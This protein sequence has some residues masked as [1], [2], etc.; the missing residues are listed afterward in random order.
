MSPYLAFY[1][2]AKDTNPDP[3]PMRVQP[4]NVPAAKFDGLS[5]EFPWWKERPNTLKLSSLL[6][7]CTLSPPSN[8]NR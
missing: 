4:V 3:R 8:M 7:M 2:A 5:L 1:M 6:H